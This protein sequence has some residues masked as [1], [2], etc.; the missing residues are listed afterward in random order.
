[1]VQVDA[2]AW[3]RPLSQAPAWIKPL[4]L[5]DR[6]VELTSAAQQRELGR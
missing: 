4:T 2:E 5:G 6:H 1:M 3:R